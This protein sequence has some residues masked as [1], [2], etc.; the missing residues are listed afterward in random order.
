MQ[1]VKLLDAV[2]FESKLKNL[3]VEYFKDPVNYVRRV[4]AAALV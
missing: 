1:V 2:A 3:L 4:S